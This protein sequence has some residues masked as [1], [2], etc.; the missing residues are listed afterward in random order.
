M[1]SGW[2]WVRYCSNLENILWNPFS[3]DVTSVSFTNWKGNDRKKIIKSFL[4]LLYQLGVNQVCHIWRVSTGHWSGDVSSWHHVIVSEY[5]NT[6]VTL[7]NIYICHQ[8]ASIISSSVIYLSMYLSTN[9]SYDPV[10]AHWL[11]WWWWWC[12]GWNVC[13]NFDCLIRVLLLPG[14][15]FVY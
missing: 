13:F 8:S 14:K 1:N 12:H 2:K 10:F 11:R 9:T 5:V 6:G 15:L 3:R 7:D 4:L